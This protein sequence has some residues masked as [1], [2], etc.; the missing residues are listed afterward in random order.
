M[1]EPSL[2]GKS[3]VWADKCCPSHVNTS[4]IVLRKLVISLAR[5]GPRRSIKPAKYDEMMKE[6]DRAANLLDRS[7]GSCQ[8]MINKVNDDVE[9]NQAKLDAIGNPGSDGELGVLVQLEAACKLQG[10]LLPRITEASVTKGI[11][12]RIGSL[13]KEGHDAR[14]NSAAQELAAI[15]ASAQSPDDGKLASLLKLQG[16]LLPRITEAGV[17]KAIK[18]TMAKQKNSIA[19]VQKTAATTGLPVG[20]RL[21]SDRSYESACGKKGCMQHNRGKPFKFQHK[22]H[23]VVARWYAAHVAENPET[24]HAE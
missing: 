21:R 24:R 1:D 5:L 22:D 12:T 9:A 6:Q 20:V 2:S 16:E 17:T 15:D 8:T 10:E 7:K 13:R 4:I 3:G 18:T 19:T 11:N 23:V 14:A